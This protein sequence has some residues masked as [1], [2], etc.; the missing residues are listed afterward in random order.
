MSRQRQVNYKD[1]GANPMRPKR[2]S[3]PSLARRASRYT[4]NLTTWTAPGSLEALTSGKL[5]LMASSA[6][7][8]ALSST[9]CQVGV[10]RPGAARI[11]HRLPTFLLLAEVMVLRGSHWSLQ[12][13]GR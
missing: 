2:M 9:S 6:V 1:R 3:S 10:G 12:V 8:A 5:R 11:E 4:Q 7:P 13:R